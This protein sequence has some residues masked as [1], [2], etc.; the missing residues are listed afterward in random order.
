MVKD[1]LLKTV[2]LA[3]DYTE[4]MCFTF[5]TKHSVAETLAGREH[6]WVQSGLVFGFIIIFDN[7]GLL[8]SIKIIHHCL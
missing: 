4:G 6:E 2:N 3:C 1:K 8:K 5:Y 7:Y